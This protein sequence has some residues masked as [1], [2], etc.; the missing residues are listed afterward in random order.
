MLWSRIEHFLVLSIE[1]WASVKFLAPVHPQ[2]VNLIRELTKPEER[3]AI[4]DVQ[5]WLYLVEAKRASKF[6]VHPSVMA[7][8][9]RQVRESMNGVE[10]IFL[11]RQPADRFGIHAEEFGRILWPELRKGKFSL[12]AEGVHLLAWRRDPN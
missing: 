5:D 12:V 4:R 6:T 8:T 7:F 10:L 1:P 2:D 3:V 11:P 9:A